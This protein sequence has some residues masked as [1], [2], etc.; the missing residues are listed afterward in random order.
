MGQG[1]FKEIT[2][3]QEGV[4]EG[5]ET[6]KASPFPS[7][8]APSFPLFFCFDVGSDVWDSHLQKCVWTFFF[9]FC[10]KQTFKLFSMW[11]QNITIYQLHLELLVSITHFPTH[12]FLQAF[13]ILHDKNQ[14]NENKTGWSL[15]WRTIYLAVWRDSKRFLT[16]QSTLTK[17]IVA[18]L[19][20]KWLV[21]TE[22]LFD[23][24]SARIDKFLVAEDHD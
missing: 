10:D 16:I 20:S 11:F 17:P 9:F 5:Q 24:L 4:L 14:W 15:F 2:R 12:F 7:F 6:S 18:Q 21:L 23:Q 22:Y 3:T 13:F 1:L 19:Q 8:S